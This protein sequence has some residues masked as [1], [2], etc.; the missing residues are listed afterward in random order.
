MFRMHH[1]NL[2]GFTTFISVQLLS[3]ESE[4]WVHARTQIQNNS[5]KNM[6]DTRKIH[7]INLIQNL[8]LNDGLAL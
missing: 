7:R 1:N 3:L 6:K 4:T 2:V 8:Y 5:T